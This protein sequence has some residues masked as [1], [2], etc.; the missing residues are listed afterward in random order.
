MLTGTAGRSQRN[1]HH[2]R[3]EKQS[4][5]RLL[6]KRE[7]LFLSKFIQKRQ[8]ARKLVRMVE[9]FSGLSSVRNGY[10]A[11][12]MGPSGLH[13]GRQQKGRLFCRPPHKPPIDTNL[14]D[15]PP[16]PEG[17]DTKL[18]PVFARRLTVACGAPCSNHG[19]IKA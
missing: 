6:H 11:P 14:L 3:Y 7:W 4:C 12:P 5:L 10:N 15:L 13:S 18:T 1:K 16:R 2:Q 17:C 9:F 19:E 8:T